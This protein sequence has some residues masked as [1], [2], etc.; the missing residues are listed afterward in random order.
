MK[1]AV[2]KDTYDPY[3]IIRSF[4][5]NFDAKTPKLGTNYQHQIFKTLITLDLFL[6]T[7]IIEK[8]L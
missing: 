2:G 5:I 8:I 4:V 1:D 3:L 7:T 6:S